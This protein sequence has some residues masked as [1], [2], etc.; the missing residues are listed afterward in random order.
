MRRTHFLEGLRLHTSLVKRVQTGTITIS[1]SSSSN[2]ASIS[3][4]NR[5]NT[6]LLLSV[7]N[8]SH[9]G[10][11]LIN[12]TDLIRGEITSDTVVTATRGGTTGTCTIRYEATE[13][14]PG[15]IKRIQR[16]TVTASGA[17]GNTTISEVDLNKVFLNR[18]GHSNNTNAAT[19]LP[20]SYLTS[21]TNLRGDF[22]AST[23]SVHGAEVAEFY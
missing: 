7:T 15:V 9:D 8:Q 12:G 16:V 20:Q 2:T 5:R 22:L 19:G 13:F 3:K 14:R 18:T 21:S 23:T 11:N 10:A 1:P 17:T 6:M 4:V